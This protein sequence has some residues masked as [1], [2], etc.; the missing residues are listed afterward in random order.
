MTIRTRLSLWYAASCSSRCSIIGVLLYYQIII[1]PREHAGDIPN[2]TT[3]NTAIDEDMFED[4]TGIVMWCAVPA[5]LLS[6][7][8]GWWLMKKSLAPVAGLTQAAEKI[9]AQNLSRTPAPHRQWR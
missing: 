3:R 8:G 5:V 2:V 6:V 1:E 4:V 9:S 7:G